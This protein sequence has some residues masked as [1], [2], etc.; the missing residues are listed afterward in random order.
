[1]EIFLIIFNLNALFFDKGIKF[2]GE[3]DS[4]WKV[5]DSIM[6][7][8]M[9]YPFYDSTSTYKTTVK[10]IYD[11][12]NLYFL[13]RINYKEEKPRKEL[14]GKKDKISIY[15]DPLLSKVN[16]YYFAIYLDGKRQDGILTQDGRNFDDSWDSVWENVSKIIKNEKG[17]YIYISEI[18]IPFKTINFSKD[19]NEWG[20]QVKT[21]FYK[22]K[23]VNYY[24]LPDQKE[25]LR[26]SKFGLL[27]NINPPL[28][29]YGI[30]FYPV[31]LFKNDYY[32]R[33][34]ENLKGEFHPWIGSDI[35]YR[36]ENHTLNLAVLPDFAEIES[37]PFTMSFSKYE[38]Y[39]PERRPF[40]I[41]GK[42][43]F[44]PSGSGHWGFY[45]PAKIF[46]SR[47]IGRKMLDGTG[48][49]PILSGL[50]YTFKSNIYETGILS[51]LTGRKNGDFDT[52]YQTL[53][54]VLRLKRYFLVNSESGF[55]ITYMKNLEK[56][57]Y[58]LGG[59]IDGA[60]RWQRNQLAYQ[61]ISTLKGKGRIG[62][63][64][65]SGGNIFIKENYVLILSGKYV[66]NYID[67]SEMGY[68]NFYPGDRSF[69]FGP[70][71]LK[72]NKRGIISNY[73]LSA[74]YFYLK[75][76]IERGNSNLFFIENNIGLRNPNTWIYLSIGTGKAFEKDTEFIYKSLRFNI[77]FNFTQITFYFG[78]NYN[79][80][81]N[82][83]R[84]YLAYTLTPYF[85]FELPA[86]GRFNFSIETNGWTEFDERNSYIQTL[87]SNKIYLTYNFTPFM[88][89][90]F[91][92]NPA[93][94]F[95]KE[96]TKLT[97]LRTSI[98]Y[99]YEVKPKSKIFLVYN[100]SFNYENQKFSNLER[101][102]GVK[103][104]WIFLF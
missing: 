47:R 84:N 73:S 3:V 64:L 93:L 51:V 89:L 78:T 50:K 35:L 28:K 100:H 53:W 48:E 65:S 42:N 27:K 56:N 92:L 34:D 29:G 74:V 58:Y 33:R 19:K 2:D 4:I 96:K 76:G 20:F 54:N 81:W 31:C 59:D 88:N 22:T 18:K 68:Q 104:K 39:Y 101:I 9:F 83:I 63:L 44:E 61:A 24:I 94:L 102:G 38:I 86:T 52:S 103:V 49:V 67:I 98:Y 46:Y 37:D 97:Y 26:V 6:V 16:A 17:E 57:E 8:K 36:K 12:N 71:Y 14:S 82:Y 99:T 30:E 85:G 77:N 21:E 23:E 13:I 32:H 40:F 60:I 80:D 25:D 10:S 87:T 69:L 79:Y 11:E 43:I 41:E 95:E 90:T 1:M 15:I 91:Y 55:L 72:F 5:S 45:S 70:V 7:D 62:F 66:N 75:E